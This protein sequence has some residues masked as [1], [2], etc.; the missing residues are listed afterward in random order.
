MFAPGQAYVAI[1]RAKTW[2]SLTLTALDFDVIRTDEQ[3]I[4]DYQK[5]QDKYDRLVLS[6]GF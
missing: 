5:L 1:S 3:V 6:F 4:A 2:D